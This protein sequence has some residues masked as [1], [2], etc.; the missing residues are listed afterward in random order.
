MH[1][2][3]GS[4]NRPRLFLKMK[5]GAHYDIAVWQ[6]HETEGNC[7]LVIRTNNGIAFLLPNSSLQLPPLLSHYGA[8]LQCLNLLRS[9]EEEID[10]FYE[11]D[12]HG[13]LSKS[14]K[15][16]IMQVASSN[17][18]HLD[19][20][21]GLRTLS[22]YV[23]PLY[24]VCGIAATNEKLQPYIRNAR[25]HGWRSPNVHIDKE[26]LVDLD[27]W[28]Q[29]YRPSEVRICYNRPEDVLIKPPTRVEV[30]D[31]DSQVTCFFK[32]FNTSLGN[33]HA[34]TELMKFKMID[35]ANIPFPPDALV[36]RLHGVV[37]E[38]NSLAGM[39]LTWIDKKGLLGRARAEEASIQ[40]RKRW[41][42]QVSGSLQVL[43]RQGIIWGDVKA[44]NVLVDKDDN[45]WIIDFGGS[46]TPGWVDEDKAGTLEGGL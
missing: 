25:D 27:R 41:A 17:S 20:T 12:A 24:F 19:Q 9:G 45:S 18:K 8:V 42:G 34:K 26:F 21:R 28:T 30:G 5:N 32:Q 2:H 43:H 31:E 3:P 23:S 4:K 35:L 7:E 13:W 29:S 11:E 14:F 46:Y 15:P 16:L 39:L 36:C 10:D 40:L 1:H 22:Q 44:E 33:N 6:V 37:R 38:G